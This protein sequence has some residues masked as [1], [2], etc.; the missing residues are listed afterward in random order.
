MAK[1][2]IIK[3]S[4]LHKIYGGKDEKQYEALKGINFDVQPGEFVGIMGASGSGKTTLLNM[5]ATLDRPTSGTVEINNQ[6][7]TK[8]RGN[9]IADFRANEIGFIFQDFNLLETLTAYENIALPLSLQGVNKRK[10]KA[11][12]QQVSSTLSISS[13]LEKYPTELSGGQKQ[14][15][16]AARAIVHNPALLLGDEPTGALDSNSARE[17]LELLTEINHDQ[18]VSVLLVTHDPFSASFS[19]RILFIKDGIIGQEVKRNG[20]S[21]TE[22]YQTILEQLGTFEQ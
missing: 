7:V 3:V 2:P 4:D 10:I 21:R 5:I 8:L 12:V 22:F 9:K 16:A 11:A 20:A 17:L 19:D 18:N 1:Q 14:R 13:L 15:V 6:D